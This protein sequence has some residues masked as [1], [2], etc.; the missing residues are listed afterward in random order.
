M[1]PVTAHKESE[2]KNWLVLKCLRRF[3]T[4][5]WK[6]SLV[7]LCPFFLGITWGG[8]NLRKIRMIVHV[9]RN[10]GCVWGKWEISHWPPWS[11]DFSRD[12][13]SLEKTQLHNLSWIENASACK[14]ESA[15]FCQ[16][17]IVVHALSNL[18]NCLAL[19]RLLESEPKKSLPAKNVFRSKC[20]VST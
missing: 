5:R 4:G 8:K 13:S 16:C 1:C 14:H 20:Q 11:L 6:V 15:C 12:V 10:P 7:V 18:C 19:E 17:W 9:S 3:W 2:V